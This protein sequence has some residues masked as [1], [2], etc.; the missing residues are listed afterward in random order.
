MPR[1]LNKPKFHILLHLVTHVCRF[2]LAILFATE[3]FK[4]YNA[5]IRDLSIHSNRLA[6]S[7][8]IGKAFAQTTRIRHFLSGGLFPRPDGE[9]KTYKRDFSVLQKTDFSSVGPQVL[10]LA[11][12]DEELWPLCGKH[13]KSKF[14]IQNRILT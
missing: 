12:N 6:P 10:A 13:E 1:W 4:S 5:I 9:G 11:R 14:N 7:R 8:D 3:V 2:G